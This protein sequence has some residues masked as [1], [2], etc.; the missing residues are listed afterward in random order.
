M[1]M[2]DTFRLY[3]LTQTITLIMLIGAL[4][5]GLF[6]SL[7]SGLLVYFIVEFGTRVLGRMGIVASTGKI[8]LLAFVASILTAL[9]VWGCLSA[10]SYVSEGPESFV[11][12]LQRMADIVTTVKTYLP[13]WTLK[14]MPENMDDWQKMTAD[15]LL[16]NAGHFS[17]F[18]KEVGTLIVHIVFGMIIGGMIAIRPAFQ[19]P[20]RPLAQALKE[21]VELLSEAFHRIVF[22]QIRI[23]ALNTVL[24]GIFLV[25]ILP[26]AGYPLP[27]TKTMIVVTFLVGLLP[28]IG[29]LISNTVIFLIAL[30]VSPVAAI[31]ALTFLIVIHKVEY[32]FNAHIIGSRIRARAW[33]LLLAMLVMESIFGMVGLIAAPIYYAYLKEE[34]SRQELI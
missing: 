18:G 5:L 11:V 30:S 2:T 32:F 29:N 3:L 19:N 23:S 22:S 15:W 12:L 6:P 8:I 13:E 33:E 26:M 14:Y 16:R 4:T 27:L 7:L 25:I 31:G 24:T 34:L 10:A 17:D 20:H 28:I 21:R 1:P 9:V